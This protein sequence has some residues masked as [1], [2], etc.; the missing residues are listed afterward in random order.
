MKSSWLRLTFLLLVLTMV[1]TGISSA[2]TGIMRCLDGNYACSSFDHGSCVYSLNASGCCVASGCLGYC[3]SDP[4]PPDT[5]LCDDGSLVYC[6]S[7]NHGTCSYHYD[8]ASGCCVASG[9]VGY[10][11]V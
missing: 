3:C 4:L 10:C 7:F 8:T 5:M 2:G 9:C 1:W 6:P 11:C